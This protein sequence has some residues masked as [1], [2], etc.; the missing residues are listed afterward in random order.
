MFALAEKGII[1]V[2]PN[3]VKSLIK[4]HMNQADE[5]LI[6]EQALKV[7]I[8]SKKDKQFDEIQQNIDPN[9]QRTISLKLEDIS[10]QCLG[11]ILR[12]IKNDCM[13]PN[14]KLILS[15]I[16]ECFGFKPN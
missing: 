4:I 11:W 8:F 6:L 7:K 14:E 9:V 15:R 10:V 3:H 13:T 2:S 16:K 1:L 12:S 5:D